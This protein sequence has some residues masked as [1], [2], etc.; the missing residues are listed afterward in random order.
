MAYT[1]IE[2]GNMDKAQADIVKEKINGKSYM[3]FRVICAPIGGSY[4]VSVE[5]DYDGTPEEIQEMLF[6]IMASELRE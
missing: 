6:F 5:T 4:R 1:N 2:I 3:D